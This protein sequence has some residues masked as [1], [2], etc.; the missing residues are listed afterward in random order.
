VL[1]AVS[2]GLMAPASFGQAV[3]LHGESFE[4]VGVGNETT[5]GPF[6]CD[7]NGNTT[8][9]FETNGFAFG[10]YSGTF[11]ESGTITIGPQTETS[12]DMR[13]VGGILAFEA[14][15]TIQSTFPVGTVTGTKRLSPSSP[16]TPSLPTAFGF[17]YPDGSSP[18]NEVFAIVPDPYVLY[19]AQ[20]NATTGS[21]T[22]SGTGSVL[23]SSAPTLSNPAT[24]MEAFNSTD[25]LP[26]EDGNNGLGHGVG[27]PKKNNDNDDDEDCG[28]D[29]EGEDG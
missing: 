5:F 24:F 28:E 21:R 9:Q 6:T 25:P 8:I 3:S 16:T 23:M 1:T 14:T 7:R 18:P 22:D 19:D 15:F 13:G 10:P 11:T 27:H 20:I 26:C 17:C 4:T 12:L 2:F 29:A